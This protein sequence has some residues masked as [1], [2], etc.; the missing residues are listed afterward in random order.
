MAVSGRRRQGGGFLQVRLRRRRA[1]APRGDVGVLQV[2]RLGIGEA[3][4]WVQFDPG[5][6]PH[7][8]GG[9]PPV[10]MILTV[11]DPDAR[12]VQKS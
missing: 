7:A 2:A 8:L 12:R 5:G 3:D 9:S 4:F 1:G 11:D 6:N 10:R